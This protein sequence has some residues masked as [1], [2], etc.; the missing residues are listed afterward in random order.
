MNWWRKLT[1]PR[2]LESFFATQR[3]ADCGSPNLLTR[4]DGGHDELVKC[5]EC[6]AVFGV[7]N[8]PFSLIERV[9]ITA[10]NRPEAK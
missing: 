6:G 10:A 5:S 2:R 9:S 8:P 1:Y 7:Q 3:C 4:Q